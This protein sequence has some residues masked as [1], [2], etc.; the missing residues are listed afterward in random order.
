MEFRTRPAI[1][2]DG[3]RRTTRGSPRQDRDGYPTWVAEPFSA[4]G[5]SQIVPGDWTRRDVCG[6]SPTPLT[7]M[8]IDEDVG[9]LC[10][11]DPI[12]CASSAMRRRIRSTAS[13]I[14]SIASDRLS[15]RLVRAGCRGRWGQAACGSL[16]R[17]ARCA[18]YR[19]RGFG[20]SSAVVVLIGCK[21][22]EPG[23]CWWRAGAGAE[24][25]WFV[26]REAPGPG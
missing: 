18:R 26:H 17:S 3:A 7:V 22:R 19:F 10:G 13:T 25:V 21:K 1:A 8:L 15:W 9:S 16:G 20:L 12:D 5:Q 4:K 14:E 11:S 23:R 6:V 24:L 2:S